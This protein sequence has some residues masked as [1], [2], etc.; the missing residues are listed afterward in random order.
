MKLKKRVIVLALSLVLAIPAI[1]F[2]NDDL[3]IL[4]NDKLGNKILHE[5][6]GHCDRKEIPEET[7]VKIKELKEK[8]KKGE[9]DNEQFHEEMHKLFPEKPHLD[10]KGSFNELP[11]ETKVKLQELKEKLKKGEITEEEFQK[12]VDKIMP[13]NEMPKKLN[14]KKPKKDQ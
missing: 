3:I 4:A 11:E 5:E 14:P 8:L 7:K 10:D 6:K 2:A 9:I 1:S 13:K 12:E